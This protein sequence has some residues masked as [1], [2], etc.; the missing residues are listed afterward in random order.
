MLWSRGFTHD[1]HAQLQPPLELSRISTLPLAAE[2]LVHHTK[3]GSRI[4]IH[5]D[6]DADGISGAAVLL[7]GLRAL[8]ANVSA[9][10][11]NRLTDGYGVSPARVAEHAEQAD[12]FI[13]VDCGISNLTEIT[14]LQKAGVEVIV[15]D[16]HTIGAALPDCLVV[17]PGQVP[18]SGTPNPGELTGAGVAYHLLWTVHRLLGLPAP[19]EYSDLAA[20]GTVAD[21]A[22]LLGENRALVT[23]GLK[24]MRNSN[25]AGLRASLAQAKMRGPLTARQLAFVLAPRL[26]AAGRLGEADLG[27]ELLTTSVEHRAR[28]LAIYLDA[29]NEERR[30]IQDEMFERTLQDLDHEA[31]ALVVHD[32][33]GHPGVMGIVASKLLER[34]W[35]PVFIMTQGKGSVRSTPGISAIRALDAAGRHLQRYGGHEQ[36]AGFSL[37]PQHLP[38][39]RTAIEQFVAMHPVPR[40][41]VLLDSL[42]AAG[43]AS[44][45]LVRAVEALEPLGEGLPEPVFGLTGNL[46]MAR[47]VGRNQATLQLRLAG[48]KGVAWQ[49]GNQAAA[50]R[51]G[52]QLNAAVRLQETEWQGRKQI[53]FIASSLRPAAPLVASDGSLCTGHDGAAWQVRRGPPG[54]TDVRRWERDGGASA[55]DVLLLDRFPL[56]SDLA[57]LTLEITQLLASGAT[58]FF[59]LDERALAAVDAAAG[60]L[61]TIA[62]ARKG[63]VVLQRGHE[64]PW[65]AQ[66]NSLVRLALSELELLDGRGFPLRGQKRKPLSSPTLLASKMA[67][68]QLFTFTSAYRHY[69]A[70]GFALAVQRLFGS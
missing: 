31:P 5:G 30:R 11:P 16:H 13:T 65:S 63:F 3:T 55:A 26:N 10:I 48:L 52:E 45:S 23:A 4:L 9:F 58:L 19:L 54:Q 8:G 40:R 28:E 69:D 35:K 43:D 56:G 66:R 24:Q 61:I 37:D 57:T 70:A 67:R 29:R 46:E 6:Y 51:P 2:R 32:E 49:M 15:T 34:Y 22:P 20:I 59:D 14:E 18:A 36:A 41:Q 44:A 17:H 62:D 68:Y 21:V 1:V 53:E 25:W 42:L 39:F 12:L 64:L 33:D 7:L 50:L 60:Q 27:L 38:L 47:A